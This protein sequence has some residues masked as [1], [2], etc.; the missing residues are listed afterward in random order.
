MSS[1]KRLYRMPA[2]GRVAGVSAGIAEY[3]EADVTLIRLAWVVLSI[4]PGCLVGGF[5]A[6]LLAWAIM[7]ESSAA[8]E[9]PA[10][11][12]R[13]VRSASDRKIAG[14]CGGL[15]EYLSIDG[16]AVRLLWVVLTIFPG[17]IVLGLVAYV[18]AWF[19]MPESA[20]SRGMVAPSPA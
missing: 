2:A 4:V 1:P 3:L 19:I 12:R 15:A 6:Y 8:P 20:P 5:L 17:A 11:H 13:L 7:P 10:G 14:V 16:T 18:V 9:V